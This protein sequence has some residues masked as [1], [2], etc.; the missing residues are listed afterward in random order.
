MFGFATISMT[1]FGSTASVYAGTTR[2][3]MRSARVEVAC[4]LVTGEVMAK[5]YP[6]IDASW[7][8][9]ISGGG[10]GRIA[11][12]L[13]MPC[14]GFCAA[15]IVKRME[16]PAS[17]SSLA[18]LH[19]AGSNQRWFLEIAG[20]AFA[21]M[22]FHTDGERFSG[23][24]FAAVG[25]RIQPEPGDERQRTVNFFALAPQAAHQRNNRGRS[26]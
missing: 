6:L 10:S 1:C 2:G 15:E 21:M 9:V 12:E 5:E 26:L 8:A 17:G 4:T 19:S 25:K 20:N 13:S 14:C 7:L 16:P 23:D 11:T 3:A 22:G 24:D 18:T